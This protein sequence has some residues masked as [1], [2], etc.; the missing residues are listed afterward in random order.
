M[1]KDEYIKCYEKHRAGQCA[2]EEEKVLKDLHDDFHLKDHA[3]DTEILGDRQEMEQRLLEQLQHLLAAQDELFWLWK[4]FNL[5]L[6]P[7]AHKEYP[8]PNGVLTRNK[9]ITR[10][11]YPAPSTEIKTNPNLR[12]TPGY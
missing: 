11:L 3:W 7:T 10:R 2:P 12:P 4:W 5:N 1:T 9:D 8:L 6:R